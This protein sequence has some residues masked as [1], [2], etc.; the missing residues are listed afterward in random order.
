MREYFTE[1]GLVIPPRKM[2]NGYTFDGAEDMT[3]F[4]RKEVGFR[5]HW[6][7]DVD[8]EY[9]LFKNLTK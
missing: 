9:N 5:K 7:F 4:E 1:K 3:F 8:C 6:F 2:Y